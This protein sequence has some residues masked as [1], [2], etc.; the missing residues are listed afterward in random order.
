VIT[1]ERKSHANG[2][3][4]EV[5][6]G[7]LETLQSEARALDGAVKHFW[8]VKA[9]KSADAGADVCVSTRSVWLSLHTLVNVQRIAASADLLSDLE[10]KLK[11]ALSAARAMDVKVESLGIDEDQRAAFKSLVIESITARIASI[12]VLKKGR[13]VSEFTRVGIHDPSESPEYVEIEWP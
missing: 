7:Q 11:K 2:L 10:G 12:G 3:L 5:A 8:S 4:T 9:K 13:P 1:T 6:L